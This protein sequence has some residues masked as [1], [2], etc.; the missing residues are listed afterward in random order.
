MKAASQSNYGPPSVLKVQ[1]VERPSVGKGQILIEVHASPVT[2]GDRRL[3]AA[4]F[5]GIGAVIGRLM[6]GVF[7]PR[8]PVPGT[9]FAGRVVEL[10]EGV[11]RFA[12]GDRVFGSCDN[13][14]HAELL[15]V[16]AGSAVAHIPEGIDT[17]AAAATPY[18]AVTALV[19][20][21]DIAKVQPGERVLVVGA[22][23]G[24]GRYGV[25][26]AKHLGATVT[27][28]CGGRDADL[29]RDL[30]ARDVIDYKTTDY[31]QTGATWDV[32]FDTVTGAGFSA[33]R[34][35]LSDGGRYVTLYMELR[36]LMQGLISSL[37]SG[38]KAKAGVAMGS[39]QLLSDL[40]EL[41]AAGSVRPTVAQTFPLSRI[42][43]AHAALEAGV[44]G[45]VMVAIQPA[46]RLAKVS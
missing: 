24:V 8:Y 10:G 39:Q 21:R 13:G 42:G 46:L 19:F 45:E 32:V 5:P 18:G 26:I 33:A 23:G 31:T 4:D 28:V 36:T 29:V 11:T 27:A 16:D 1:E 3:R 43:E 25:Q 17:Q 44:H 37:S 12:V 38:P 7:A 40:A 15:A 9:M 30:G 20:L 14:A 2:H 34:T 41:L 6:F 22:A 35:C